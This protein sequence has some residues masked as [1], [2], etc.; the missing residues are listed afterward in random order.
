MVSWH[1]IFTSMWNISMPISTVLSQTISICNAIY[2]FTC[3]QISLMCLIDPYSFFIVSKI[4]SNIC[5]VLN[6]K[7]IIELYADGVRVS[8]LFTY[9]SFLPRC[10]IRRGFL[11]WKLFLVHFRY[12][13]IST[14]HIT[15]K[16]PTTLKFSFFMSL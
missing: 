6:C 1:W 7:H 14:I 16:S 8:C 2:H 12:H 11:L 4:V 3:Q 15:S 9:N 10:Y 5:S 13:F